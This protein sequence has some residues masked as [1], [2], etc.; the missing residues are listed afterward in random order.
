MDTPPARKECKE[1]VQTLGKPCHHPLAY[2]WSRLIEALQA[3][4][5]LQRIS[6]GLLLTGNDLRNKNFQFTNKGI[7]C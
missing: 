3:T 7:G 5:D 1:I 2:D 6:V 4:E